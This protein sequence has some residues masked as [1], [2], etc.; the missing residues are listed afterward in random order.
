MKIRRLEA[1]AVVA[2]ALAGAAAAQAAPLESTTSTTSYHRVQVDGVWCCQVVEWFMCHSA[3]GCHIMCEW[4][5]GRPA[6][7]P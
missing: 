7:S 1:A 4:R 5:C 2:A 3:F 6:A